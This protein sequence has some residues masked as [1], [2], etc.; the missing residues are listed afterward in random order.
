MLPPLLGVLFL[1]ILLTVKA[2]LL[3]NAPVSGFLYFWPSDFWSTV[4]I[5][6]VFMGLQSI[7]Y[8]LLMEFIGQRI[9]T[10]SGGVAGKSFYVILSIALGVAA[11]V[12][13][14]LLRFVSIGA[15]VGFIVGSVLLLIHKPA[16]EE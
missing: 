12:T 9:L 2:G 15:I 14:S 7:I 16:S 10:R 11:G 3:K 4:P 13:T 5:A 8:S 1:F 6:Y